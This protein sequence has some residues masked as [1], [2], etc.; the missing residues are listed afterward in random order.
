ML[1]YITFFSNS[2]TTN[3]GKARTLGEALKII[4][5]WAS[6]CDL[7][8]PKVDKQRKKEKMFV[9]IKKINTNKVSYLYFS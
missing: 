1:Y 3:I 7:P 6:K 5:F 4:S 2:E 8:T 9:T